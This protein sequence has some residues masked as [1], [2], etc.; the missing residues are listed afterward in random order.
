MN[1]YFCKE[2]IYCDAYKSSIWAFTCYTCDVCHH[3]DIK[4]QLAYLHIYYKKFKII[5]DINNQSAILQFTNSKKS[6]QW[7]DDPHWDTISDLSYEISKWSL[8]D[9]YNKLDLYLYFI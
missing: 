5:L 4:H 6:D 1:C 8:L 7:W 3:M 9:I 2:E